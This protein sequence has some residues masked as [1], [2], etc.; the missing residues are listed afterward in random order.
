[1]YNCC[2][3]KYSTLID[4]QMYEDCVLYRNGQPEVIPDHLDFQRAYGEL[5]V[6]IDCGR[7]HDMTVIWV[8]EKLR[9]PRP[10]TPEHLRDIYRTV[11]VNW[12]RNVPFGV[13]EQVILSIVRH[14]AVSRCLIDRGTIGA[15]MAERLADE[16]GSVVEPFTMT[17][18][19]MAMMAERL[20]AF[21]QQRRI[22]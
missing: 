4:A 14:P 15:E 3:A 17:A 8:L 11:C 6:G 5:F 1:E 21:V 7:V 12:M 19:R 10:E 9:D 16:M 13:Q 18:P 20:R 22:T 2:P